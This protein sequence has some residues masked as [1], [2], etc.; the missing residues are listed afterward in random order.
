[1]AKLDLKE[2]L[3]KDYAYEENKVKEIARGTIS[4]FLGVDTEDVSV[5]AAGPNEKGI[6][7]YLKAGDFDFIYNHPSG[8]IEF[9][10]D[11]QLYDVEKSSDVGRIISFKDNK[12]K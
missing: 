9:S 2:K 10:L 12:F 5:G 6:R 1:M 3:I 11:G 4:S 7:V 8:K